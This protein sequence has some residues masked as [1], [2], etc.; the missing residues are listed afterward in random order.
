MFDLNE[1]EKPW[2]VVGAPTHTLRIV[3][4][5]AREED[6]GPRFL[7][8]SREGGGVGERGSLE[9]VC[10]SQRLFARAF[11]PA[12]DPDTSRP[13]AMCGVRAQKSGLS[14]YG[15]GLLAALLGL[16][17][18]SQHAQTA[19]PTNV[20][21]A[22][23]NTTTQIMKSTL[24]LSESKERGARVAF[25]IGGR[26]PVGVSPPFSFPPFPYPSVPFLPLWNISSQENLRAFTLKR[27]SSRLGTY[28][29]GP[30]RCWL[31]PIDLVF[32]VQGQGSLSA[33]PQSS[34][35]WGSLKMTTAQKNNGLCQLQLLPLQSC[36]L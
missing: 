10:R 22:A 24:S 26:F 29:D 18:L 15:A 16:S 31:L 21:S 11:G 36:V 27:R 7:L 5:K 12:R 4:V 25:K 14:G 1:M 2:D 9:A 33:A 13:D 30:L 17:F 6:H 3:S 19:E 8:S 32:S 35:G 20:T 34:L 23:N 28:T